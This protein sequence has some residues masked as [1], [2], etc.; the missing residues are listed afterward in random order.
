[1]SKAEMGDSPFTI[2]EGFPELL[3]D[4]T[5]SV[6]R[7]RPGDVV[8]YAVVYFTDLANRRNP[9]RNQNSAPTNGIETSASVVEPKKSGVKFVESVQ[10]LD[11]DEGP[12]ED[13]PA[14]LID[15]AAMGQNNANDDDD[16]YSD[17]DLDEVPEM[18]L[19]AIKPMDFQGPPSFAKGRRASVSAEPLNMEDDISN[20]R[21]IHPKSDE[22]R[23]RLQGAVMDILMFRSL[24]QE[25]REYV[26][27]AMFEK[28]ALKDE[29]VIELGDDGDFFYV[30]D[31]GKLDC[32]VKISGEEK[33]VKTYSNGES[34]GE[35][36]LMYNTPRAATIIATEDSVLWA[37]DRQTFRH[38]VLFKTMKK[39]NMYE[40]F[41]NAIPLLQSLESYE[42]MNLADALQSKSYKA[43]EVIITQGDDAD[44]FYIIEEGKV[45]VKVKDTQSGEGTEEGGDA[46]EVVVNEL[47]RGNYFGELAL[48]DNKPRAATVYAESDCTCALLDVKAFE[49]L[50]GPCVDILKRNADVYEQQLTALFGKCSLD[51]LRR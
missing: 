25:T 4:F 13:A 3:Q 40:E 45:V 7:E 26:L 43:G 33:M 22:Q 2:P 49:R 18:K 48:L 14:P 51:D 10:Q 24:D 9:N 5:V 38:L 42:R 20:D 44:A 31:S 29:K 1:L 8:E 39:R 30:V 11:E 15:M 12:P 36:A 34:F 21:V 50:L 27:D 32:Y 23:K 16:C 41:L 19:N 47:E 35:L 6:L 17:E 46:A 37:L 28:P